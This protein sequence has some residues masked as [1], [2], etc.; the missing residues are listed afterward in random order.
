[1]AQLLIQ[2][3][4]KLSIVCPTYNHVHFIRDALEGFVMQKTNFPFEVLIH[5]DAS[6]DG[7][8][9]IIR[10]YALKYPDIIKPTYQTENQFGKSIYICRDILFPG[11]QSKYVALCEGDDYWT[12]P[13]K[14]QKQVDFLESHPDY[15]ICFHPVK[16][17][18]ENHSKPDSLY[19]KSKMLKKMN[20]DVLLQCNFIQ[21]NSVVYR[22]RRECTKIFPDYIAPGDWFLHLL[23]AQVGKI[24]YLPEVMGVY[25][26]HAGGIWSGAGESDAWF[27]KYWM[28]HLLFYQKVQETFHCDKTAEMTE[29]MR[30]G[31]ISC[32]KVQNFKLL[33]K[34]EKTYPDC[35]YLALEKLS[36]PKRK[37]SF[38]LFRFLGLKK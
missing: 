2:Y 29:M 31:I 11:I 32:L 9:D 18:W 24:G 15:S 13:F 27:S 10:E 3:G 23:H 19:P 26:K 17:H 28:P 8:A 34:V 7:T 1:M 33:Q 30:K 37:K 5:D 25:R 35:Y 20:L 6:T 36:S 21:T 22:W 12:D 4:P 38:N 14:L 16:V